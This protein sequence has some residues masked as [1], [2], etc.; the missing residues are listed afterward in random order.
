MK[1]LLDCNTSDLKL[2]NKQ[3]K[4]DAILASEGRIVIQ[5][6]SLFGRMQVLDGVTDVGV[7]C[8][9]GADMILLNVF[10]AYH[11]Y[12]SSI[13][14]ENPNNVIRTLKKYT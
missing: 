5:E 4:L 1:R 13:K 10:D 14:V 8:T 6:I 11:P 7:V 12:I 2:M 9:F 3:E